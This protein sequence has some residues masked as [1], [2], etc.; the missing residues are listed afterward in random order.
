M[1]IKSYEILK[2]PSNFEQYNLYLL[3]GENYGLK[4]DI[5]NK[6]I[7]NNTKEDKNMEILNFYENDINDDVENFYN[8]IYSGSL[9]GNKKLININNVTDKFL[10]K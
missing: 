6:I 1:I 7:K 10:S 5:K 4:N 9:F 8:S 3:Y 2:N